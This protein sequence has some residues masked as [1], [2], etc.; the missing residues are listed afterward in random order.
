MFHFLVKKDN[1]S[2]FK[3]IQ[4]DMHSHLVPAIDDGC[5]N[6]SESI[7]L[8]KKMTDL[9][10]RKIITTPHIISDLYPNSRD[11]IL[12]AFKE[13]EQIIISEKIPITLNV[14]AEYFLD[15]YFNQ[16]LSQ[17]EI[18]SFGDTKY[19][20]C[21]ISIAAPPSNLKETI[22]N[23]LTQGYRPILAH[24]E[25]YLYWINDK[26]IIPSLIEMGC[27]MQVNISSLLGYYGKTV[28]DYSYKLIKN[29]YVSFLGTDI[30]NKK[31]LEFYI[32]QRNNLKIYNIIEKYQF[33]NISLL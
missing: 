15:N 11:S 30:H 18:L 4:V 31:H 17:K 27:L 29:N 2:F 23:I 19:L 8:I 28:E 12:A 24:L 6:I 7:S 21:E 25:R 33:L 32:N 13:L 14:A 3:N 5:Q 22:F 20:L 9:G 26:Y 16:C 1:F 10:Y